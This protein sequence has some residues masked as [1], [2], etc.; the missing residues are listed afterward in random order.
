MAFSIPPLRAKAGMVQ[1]SMAKI[2][3]VFIGTS[4]ENLSANCPGN[5]RAEIR[6]GVGLD[7]GGSIP[8][9]TPH[10]VERDSSY[11]HGHVY[12]HDVYAY[13]RGRAREFAKASIDQA[14]DI[15]SFQTTHG[16][17]PGPFCFVSKKILTR[18]TRD[19]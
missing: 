4:P 17:V 11:G 19:A 5:W 8:V 13:R 18:S 16:K 9:K 2:Q 15:K 1:Q 3:K 7:I 10:D 6:E 12:A 14:S